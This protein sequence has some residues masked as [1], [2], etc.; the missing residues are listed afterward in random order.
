MKFLSMNNIIVGASE[1]Q[2]PKQLCD[3]YTQLNYLVLGYV[4]SVSVN[5]II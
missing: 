4:V 1:P 3:I 5:G 2:V